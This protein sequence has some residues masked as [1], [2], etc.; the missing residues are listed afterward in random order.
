MAYDSRP[1]LRSPGRVIL[2]AVAGRSGVHATIASIRGHD[3][4]FDFRR[5]F[6]IVRVRIAGER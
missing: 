4:D 6:G 5:S 1:G 3:L 2:T